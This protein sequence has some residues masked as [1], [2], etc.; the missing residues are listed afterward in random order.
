MLWIIH[1]NFE[2]ISDE[3]D[4][5]LSTL[6]Q[7]AIIQIASSKLP[8]S[9]T[10]KVTTIAGCFIRLPSFTTCFTS[11]ALLKFICSLIK[12]S[13]VVSFKALMEQQTHDIARENSENSYGLD[14]P[15][16]TLPPDRES[17]M[18]GRL[19]GF[20]GRAFGGGGAATHSST[21]TIPNK[22]SF[23]RVTS[24]TGGDTHFK[25]YAEDLKETTCLQMTKMKI[26]T[27]Q[28]II[29]NIPLPLLLITV[30]AEANS[31]RLTVIE[32]AV[33]KHLCEIVARSS[34]VELRSFAME[35]LIHF[36][37]LSL[38]KSKDNMFI[39]YGSGPLMVPNREDMNELPFEVHPIQD[40]SDAKVDNIVPSE[41]QLLK[42][43]CQTIES[44]SQVDTAENC[45][46]ALLVVLEGAGHSLSGE[47]L[48]IVINTLSTLS[49]C[50]SE[51][52]EDNG[53]DNVVNRSNKKWVTVSSLAFQ[54][55]KL[56]LDEFLEQPTS[57][58]SEDSPLKS[59]EARD[60]ILDCCVAFGRSRH[61][62]NTS[63]TATGMLW[64]LADRDSSPDTLHVVLSKLAYLAMD[65]RTEVRNCSVNTLFSC[66]VG[67]GDQF[68]DKQWK[69]CL[70]DTI[71]GILNGIASAIHQ[72]G[73]K[74]SRVNGGGS[75]E[76]RYKVAVHH[77]RNSAKKQWATS[78]IL[79]LRG[80][81][82]VLR[83]FFSRL[84]EILLSSSSN[85]DLWFLQTW[86]DILQ[87]SFDC[88]IIS[89]ERETLDMR[90]TGV[91]L[92]VLCA[93]LSSKAGIVAAGN[94]ARVGT[95][96]EV[97][98][99]ALRTVR[100][101]PVEDKAR[102]VEKRVSK[103][104]QEEADKWRK[105]LFGLS[106]NKLID[107]RVFLED[108]GKTENEGSKNPMVI[109]SLLTQVLTKL[110]GELMKLYEC[111]K[112]DEMLP[113]PCE[114]KLDI[115]VENDNGYESRFLH[116]LLVI[117][118]NAGND[119]NSRFL[120]QVQRGIMALL[121]SMAANS[122]L[123]AFQTL[124]AISGDHMFV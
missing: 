26:S 75:N 108:N 94:S 52:E 89:G 100:A 19:L 63:L 112:N 64:S 118:D 14:S 123:R 76:E 47:N 34:S 66:I 85:G 21:A 25:T 13:E 9:Y 72:A 104:N 62:V 27:P 81:E 71:F 122:S 73:E 23:R 48:I 40:S 31:Y 117:A 83:T 12:L 109:D 105:D 115:S 98:G 50:E 114:L 103:T 16:K 82:R 30:V 69:T 111:C 4:I 11:D 65:D 60:A 107:L 53:N 67:L 3:W 36:M 1:L 113:G 91:E 51:E 96:M 101:A 97:V 119:K 59:V 39:K 37:P 79:V 7:L 106:F 17:S 61:D 49:G 5:I 56:I 87:V 90:L 55:L 110:T 116:L 46:N 28:N 6:D 44:S 38:S 10:E 80:L 77:S 32:E 35:V 78:Q 42:I 15:E 68:T 29:R 124:A 121:Q 120:N 18:G 92:I 43:L 8:E 54:N 102:E 33:A 2:K 70:V 20:A 99:G 74:E 95:N 93:Q 22:P 58:S 57:A 88:A 86:K 45:L 84:L 41:P 24:A